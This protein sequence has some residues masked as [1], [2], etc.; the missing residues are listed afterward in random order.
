[1]SGSMKEAS[2]GR[3]RPEGRAGGY[4]LWNRPCGRSCGCAEWN[5]RITRRRERCGEQYCGGGNLSA[6][7]APPGAALSNAS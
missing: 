4:R 5:R 3:A 1:M 2:V 6:R 7:K